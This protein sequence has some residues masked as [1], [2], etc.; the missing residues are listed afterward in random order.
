FGQAAWHPAVRTA[1]V[2]VDDPALRVGLLGL[3]F[4]KLLEDAERLDFHLTAAT[5]PRELGLS[6][7]GVLRLLRSKPARLSACHPG[8]DHSGGGRPR[9]SGPARAGWSD[10]KRARLNDIHTL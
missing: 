5:I 7:A 1:N 4:P 8:N 10:R 3:D 6:D 9:R 2:T